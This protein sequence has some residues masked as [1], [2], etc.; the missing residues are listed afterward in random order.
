VGETHPAV[1]GAA[2]KRWVSPTLLAKA[3]YSC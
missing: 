1:R 3:L 2:R